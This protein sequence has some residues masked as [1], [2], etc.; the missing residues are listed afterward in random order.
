V[1]FVQEKTTFQSLG[2]QAPQIFIRARDS[3]RLVTAHHN[4]GWGPP[5]HFKGNI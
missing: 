2:V 5:K 1:D 4:Q 3:A